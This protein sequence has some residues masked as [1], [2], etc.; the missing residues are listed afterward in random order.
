[1]VTGLLVLFMIAIT[2]V[3]LFG[4]TKRPKKRDHLFENKEGDR[5]NPFHTDE[6][7]QESPRWRH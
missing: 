7:E 5:Y 2:P 3:F 4:D 6:S 1:M